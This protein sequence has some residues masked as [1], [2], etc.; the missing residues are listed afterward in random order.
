MCL[1][2]IVPFTGLNRH[3]TDT[4]LFIYALG[5]L[6]ITTLNFKSICLPSTNVSQKLSSNLLFF[7]KFI[8][9]LSSNLLLLRSG[10]TYYFCIVHDKTSAKENTRFVLHSKRFKFT[11]TRE[12]VTYLIITKSLSNKLKLS[13]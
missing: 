11:R 2:N 10:I 13:F 7:Y 12:Q 8:G 3:K 9:K 4:K 6:K 5:I 1:L